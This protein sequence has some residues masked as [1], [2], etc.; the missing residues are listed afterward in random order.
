MK[1]LWRHR[2]LENVFLVGAFCFK[3]KLP[4]SYSDPFFPPDHRPHT[5]RST[6]SQKLLRLLKPS[7]ASGNL[8]QRI[9]VSMFY[10]LML[11]TKLDETKGSPFQIFS[12][13]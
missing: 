6:F 13:L 9:P 7:P 12:A 4:N 1:K 11:P 8:V 2:F 3:V 10:I 5:E